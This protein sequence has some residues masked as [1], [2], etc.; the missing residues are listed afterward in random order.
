MKVLFN[1]FLLLCLFACS[2]SNEKAEIVLKTNHVFQ[3]EAPLAYRESEYLMVGLADAIASDS[4]LANG[5]LHFTID[6]KN[7]EG[8]YFILDDLLIFVKPGSKM[9]LE[10][11]PRNRHESVFKGDLAEVNGWM[12][13]EIMRNARILNSPKIQGKMSYADYRKETNHVADSLLGDMKRF[14][15]GGAFETT[16][17]R[18]MNLMRAHAYG[19]Y[20]QKIIAM[21]RYRGGFETQEE[22]DVWRNELMATAQPEI[23]KDIKDI[24]SAYKEDEVISLRHGTKVL[25]ALEELQKGGIEALKYNRFVELYNH[26]LVSTFDQNFEFSAGLKGYAEKLT[27]PRLKQAMLEVVEKNRNVAEGADMQDFEFEDMEGNKHRLSEF[28]G[29]P[30]YIDVWATWC[31]PCKALAPSFAAWAKEY[32]GKNIKFLAIS[33]DSKKA[34]WTAFME[35]HGIPEDVNEWWAS[36]DK[37]M[38]TYHINSIPR[39]LLIDKNFKIK[40]AYAYKPGEVGEDESLKAL[41][42]ELVNEN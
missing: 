19:L 26:A 18:R 21:Q 5:D 2:K 33:I 36:D 30:I 10:S 41:L 17:E 31:G 7:P 20:E 22:F 13:Q 34:P 25:F 14:K 12:N 9:E 38:E 27:D 37:F 32:K 24:L 4:L 35:K 39:F 11:N 29:M 6:V 3:R 16:M 15:M 40:M 42:D 8:D 28:K 1:V 23:L